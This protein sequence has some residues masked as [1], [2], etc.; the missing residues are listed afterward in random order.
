MKLRK[1]IPEITPMMRPP[2]SA[3]ISL[4][5]F[6]CIC[7]SF[8]LVDG[9]SWLEAAFMDSAQR[10][11]KNDERDQKS[12]ERTGQKP[13]VRRDIRNSRNAESD[14]QEHGGHGEDKD[15][16]GRGTGFPKRVKQRIQ[17]DS[18]QEREVH[19]RTPHAHRERLAIKVQ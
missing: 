5:G 13:A 15:Q 8:L 3:G 2:Y 11:R 6:S 10:D 12:K 9:D 4:L 1:G 14:I 16:A 17:H 7:R 19:G 18:R